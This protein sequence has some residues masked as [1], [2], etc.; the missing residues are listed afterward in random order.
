MNRV[1]EKRKPSN[2]DRELSLRYHEVAFCPRTGILLLSVMLTL[3]ACGGNSATNNSQ[4]PLSVFGNWQF[5]MA[6]PTDGSFSGGLQGGF[7]L[8]TNTA[9]TGNVAYSITVP[10]NPQPMSSVGTASIGS[11][12]SLTGQNVTLSATAGTFTFTF[13]GT[14]SLDSTTMAGFYTCSNPSAPAGSACGTGQTEL[15][16]SAVLVPP[17]TGS[18]QGNFHSIGGPAGLAEQDFLVS[19]ALSQANNSGS[20]SSAVTGDL[21][22]LDPLSNSSD[23][24]CVPDALVSGQISGTTLNL[25]ILATDGSIVGQI[26]ESLTASSGLGTVTFNPDTQILQ[27]LSGP[28]YAVYSPA[29]GGGSLAEPAD[30]G[31][32]CL[33][34]NNSSSCAQPITL[35][36]PALSFPGQATGITTSQGVILANTGQ[37]ILSNLTLALTNNSGLNVFT[38]TDTCGS[39]GS[40]SGGGPFNLNPQ[41]AC[42]IT[43]AYTPQCGSPCSSSQK[44]TLILNSP[45]DSSIFTLPISGTLQPDSSDEWSRTRLL[46]L[47]KATTQNGQSK[48][49]WALAHPDAE[50]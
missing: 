41:Q 12:S 28:A 10:A 16:W 35:T 19:G 13:T 33:A 5:T 32:I 22:F 44:A 40:P 21:S 27:S 48:S 49:W 47:L 46:Q 34:L 50:P 9:V 39:G 36:P 8:Q 3:V 14:L 26:G 42:T 31:D 43:I 7:L 45:S 6:G 29:C 20:A 23:Y 2:I 1:T 11:P 4:I 38:E 30:F 17:L 24:P 18:I 25:Q 15:Q 37:S